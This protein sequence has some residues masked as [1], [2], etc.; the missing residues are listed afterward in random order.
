MTLDQFEVDRFG[1]RACVVDVSSI[2]KTK[3]EVG[4]LES[5]AELVQ[6][7]DFVILRSGWSRFWES[8]DYFQDFQDPD[9][10]RFVT[11]PGFFQG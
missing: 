2:A 7:S 9:F 4:V 3:V 6:A 5:R 11:V 1:G 8:E 10:Q